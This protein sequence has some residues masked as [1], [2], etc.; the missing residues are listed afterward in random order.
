MELSLKGWPDG[1]QILFRARPLPVWILGEAGVEF[2]DQHGLIFAR[3]G[4]IEKPAESLAEESDR[5]SV[6]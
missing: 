1:I 2:L 5:K 4:A 3:V 6:V